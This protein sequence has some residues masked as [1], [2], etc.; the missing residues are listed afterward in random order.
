VWRRTRAWRFL[1]GFAHGER[2]ATSARRRRKNLFRDA[3]DGRLAGSSEAALVQRGELPLLA[4]Q[5]HDVEV[6]V[7]ATK[8][9][10]D[11]LGETLLV[12]RRVYRA[13][14][15]RQAGEKMPSE[16]L[17]FGARQQPTVDGSLLSGR[18]SGHRTLHRCISQD[19]SQ[20]RPATSGLRIALKRQDN[21]RCQW[22][23]SRKRQ[24]K[25]V[26]DKPR[27][28]HAAPVQLW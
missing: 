26:Y 20:C 3:R 27:R 6:G 9:P 5:P 21:A 16:I 22:S 19:V 11:Q 7:R 18:H 8:R 23:G 10:H 15:I 2:A 13:F 25:T 12:G 4:K 28:P 14:A 24:L 1:S 17:I